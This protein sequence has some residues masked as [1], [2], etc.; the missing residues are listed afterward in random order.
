MASHSRAEIELAHDRYLD[1]RHR[2]E[3]GEAGWEALA[4]FFTDGATFIDPAWGR[5]EG[6]DAIREFLITSMKGLDD[7]SFP[8]QW[9]MIEGDRLVAEWRNRLPGKRADGTYYEAPGLTVMM[10]AGDGKFS[11]E[12]DLL[13]MVHVLQLIEESGWQPSAEVTMPPQNPRR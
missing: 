5:I 1:C 9:R 6:K 13:N 3:A 7:W 4:D 2:I 10:Y 12:E 8:H 11:Y